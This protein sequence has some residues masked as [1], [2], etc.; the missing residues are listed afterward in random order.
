MSN[1]ERDIR[2]AFFNHR[3]EIVKTVRSMHPNSATMR[4][5]NALQM[6]TYGADVVQVFEHST[7]RLLAEF[8]RRK[9]NQI[10]TTYSYDPQD[11]ANPLQ[12]ITMAAF[13]TK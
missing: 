9:S 6:N 1:Q 12:R 11:F 3:G 2:S 10:V 5:F 7:A 8:V 4:A 13:I